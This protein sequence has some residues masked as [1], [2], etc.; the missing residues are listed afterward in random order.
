M[1]L[2]GPGSPGGCWRGAAPWPLASSLTPPP[3]GQEDASGLHLNTGFAT[4]CDLA[5][6][7]QG[8]DS[9]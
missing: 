3:L 7:E 5:S 4:Q 2:A 9:S 1:I 6:R 8:W